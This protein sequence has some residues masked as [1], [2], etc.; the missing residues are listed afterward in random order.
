MYEPEDSAFNAGRLESGAINGVET[1]CSIISMP[2]EMLIRPQYGTRYFSVV[3]VFCSSVLMLLI[4]TLSS[5]STGV[6]QMI[7]FSRYVPPPG[8]FDFGSFTKL[9]FLLLFVHGFRIWRRMIHM[10]L[11]LHSEYEGPPLPFFA[12][13]PKGQSYWF[14]RIVLEPCFVYLAATALE[15]LFIVQSSLASYLHFAAF[16]LVCK[17]FVSWFLTWAYLRQIFDMRNLAPLLAKL[18]DGTATQEDLAPVHLASFPKDLDPKLRQAAAM[19]IAHSLAPEHYNEV[20]P[21]GAETHEA[22]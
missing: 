16:A 20:P 22:N 8:M 6:M 2:V 21:Q 13:V 1:L 17:N 19:H 7:P 11:E 12:L 4:P 10:E 14:T 15:D 5:L 18:V 9:Y 3:V